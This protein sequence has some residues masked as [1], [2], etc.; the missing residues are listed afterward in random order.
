[1]AGR[2][3]SVRL[4]VCPFVKAFSTMEPKRQ[5][6]S[7]WANIHSMHR[8]GGKTMVTISKQSVARGTCQVRSRKLLQKSCSPGCRSNHSTDLAENLCDR[9]PLYGDKIRLGIRWCCPFGICHSHV[10]SDF[11]NSF[12]APERL[13]RFGREG[14]FSTRTD[15]GKIALSIV[16]GSWV[17]ISTKPKR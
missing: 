17:R 13:A 2:C 16:E 3:L 6:R 14:H 5:V 4:S 9:W 11:I 8:S 7:G 10:P 15:N 12:I 1:M